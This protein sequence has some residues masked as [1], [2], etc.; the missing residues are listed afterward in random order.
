MHIRSVQSHLRS[1]SLSAR[2]LRDIKAFHCHAPPVSHFLSLPLLVYF[3]CITYNAA[4]PSSFCPGYLE[5]LEFT[6][7]R[8]KRW[9]LKVKR[10]MKFG[11]PAAASDGDPPVTWPLLASRE[12]I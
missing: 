12:I 6:G 10:A 8:G 3:S 2:I 1:P 9:E 11:G 7:V 4:F 5:P